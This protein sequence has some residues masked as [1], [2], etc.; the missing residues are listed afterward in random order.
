L[1][2][3]GLAAD[4]SYKRQPLGKQL[5]E[6]NRRGASRAAICRGATVTVKDLASGDQIDRP[7]DDFLAK[8]RG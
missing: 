8:P 6:A 4:F 2:R 7:I 1:R 5:K 3:G